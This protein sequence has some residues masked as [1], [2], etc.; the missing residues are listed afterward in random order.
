MEAKDNKNNKIHTA[1]DSYFRAAISDPRVAKDFFDAHL[2]DS[3]K[4]A[5]NL[6]SLKMQ[7]DTFVDGELRA[8]A[9]DALFSTQWKQQRPGYLYLLVE[10]QVTPSPLLAF[11]VMKYLFSIMDQHLKLYQT[12]TLPVVYPLILYQA[13]KPYPFSTK[14]LD[15]FDV[16][17]QELAKQMFTGSFQVIN[18]SKVSG[19]DIEDHL[20][21][22][23]MELFMKYAKHHEMSTLL[24]EYGV[25]LREIMRQGGDEFIKT[26]LRYLLKKGQTSNIATFMNLAADTIDDEEATMEMRSAAEQLRQ[27]GRDEAAMEM[28]SAAEQLRQQGRDEAAME[29][30]SAA[31]QLRQQ[32]V[33]QGGQEKTQLIAQNMLKK[34]LD[35][36]FICEMTGLSLDTV[37]E[38]QSKMSVD[39]AQTLQSS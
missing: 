2:P 32:G 22:G 8:T 39:E 36:Q 10:H 31:E 11:R 24:K 37:K 9:S 25:Y 16:A 13:S 33:Q 7:K 6:K 15:L 14:L 1:H 27:Q 19:N 21:S 3:V 12:K 4:S 20:W 30:R 38:I 28:R 17:H 34:R 29:M 18:I 23:G 26:S 35:T 5:I